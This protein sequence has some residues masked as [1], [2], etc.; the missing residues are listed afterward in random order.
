MGTEQLVQS[1]N[2]LLP[3]RNIGYPNARAAMSWMRQP[4]ALHK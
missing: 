2:I 1:V 3:L 4:V